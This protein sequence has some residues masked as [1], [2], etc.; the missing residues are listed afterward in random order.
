MKISATVFVNEFFGYRRDL[1]KQ[2]TRIEFA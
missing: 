2:S 1:E